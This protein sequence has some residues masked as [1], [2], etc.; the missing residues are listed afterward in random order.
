MMAIV[1]TMIMLIMWICVA[2]TNKDDADYA[3]KMVMI[4]TATL[5]MMMVVMT[6]TMMWWPMMPMR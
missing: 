5:M 1:I 3:K 2:N 4:T 6:T